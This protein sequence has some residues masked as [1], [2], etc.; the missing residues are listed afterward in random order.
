MIMEFAILQDDKTRMTRLYRKGYG[1][2]DPL[3]ASDFEVLGEL[4]RVMRHSK[5]SEFLLNMGIVI[6]DIKNESDNRN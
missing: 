2:S 6:K 5:P 1:W 3:P 4:H